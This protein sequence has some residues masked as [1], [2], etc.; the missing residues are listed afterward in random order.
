MRRAL[1]G[2]AAVGLLVLIPV[3]DRGADRL[4]E[5]RLARRWQSTQDLPARPDVDITGIPFLTQA[6]RGRYDR[7]DV[8]MRGVRRGSMRL[9][10]IDAQLSGV[11][12]PLTAAVRGRGGDVPVAAAR[13]EALLTYP[14]IAR[15]V[16]RDGFTVT[17]AGERL[18]VRGPV[19]VLG[20]DVTA[21]ALA[22]VT[23][24]RNVVRVRATRAEIPG[25]PVSAAVAARAAGQLKFAVNA[26]LPFA[27][28]LTGVRV[29]PDGL[30]ASASDQRVVLHPD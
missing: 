14:D 29:T 20:R 10:R 13:G 6:V 21:T 26:R 11:R 28:R 24:H 4:A 27:L 15:A 1:V 9:A 5:A 25:A 22:T 12:V 2:A 19:H 17:P 16:G 30:V 7:I 18:R 8:R 3:A 23:V